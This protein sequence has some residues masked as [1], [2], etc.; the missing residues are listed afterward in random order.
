VP[1]DVLHRGWHERPSAARARPA[2][3][4]LSCLRVSCNLSQQRPLG[5]RSL[6][7]K[8]IVL[9]PENLTDQRVGE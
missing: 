4:P 5:W 6:H 8:T 1:G 2:N 3:H 9:T 7:R